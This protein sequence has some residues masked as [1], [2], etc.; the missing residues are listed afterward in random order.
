M[1]NKFDIDI[2][3]L[4]RDYL[5]K[6][7]YFDF[8]LVSLSFYRLPCKI[9]YYPFIIKAFFQIPLF[10]NIEN[11]KEFK[12]KLCENSSI[13]LCFNSF[14]N[15]PSDNGYKLFENIINE[16]KEVK[17]FLDVPVKIK[18]RLID[19]W[20]KT[21]TIKKE[22]N[23]VDKNL[24]LYFSDIDNTFLLSRKKK[25]LPYRKLNYQLIL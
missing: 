19:S 12:Y 20:I 2:L 18:C 21:T 11:P 16:Y 25:P 8:N 6:K 14:N 13:Y 4:I 17:I 10:F 15:K 22:I 23:L 1:I 5:E 24:F 7:S 3:L 9:D